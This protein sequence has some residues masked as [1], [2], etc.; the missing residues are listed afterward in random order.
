[1][2]SFKGLPTMVTRCHC[3]SLFNVDHSDKIAN[4]LNKN[5]NSTT[6]LKSINERFDQI[7]LFI[8]LLFESST[9]LHLYSAKFIVKCNYLLYIT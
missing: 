9:R 6:L 2:T 4:H 1:M 5:G 3:K 8:N 7:P